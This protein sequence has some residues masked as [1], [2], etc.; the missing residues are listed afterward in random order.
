MELRQ[1]KIFSTVARERN[2]TRAAELLGYAQSNVTAQVRLL[3]DEFGTKLFERLGKRVYLSPDGEKLLQYANQI[4]KLSSEAKDALAT[5]A[6]PHGTIT[7]GVAESLCVFRLPMLFKEYCK[8][9]PQIKLILKLGASADFYRWLRDN[10]IDIAFFL[11]PEITATDLVSV[12]FLP[13][14]MVIVSNTEHRLVRKGY[15]EP[16]DLQDECLILTERGCSYRAAL[17]KILNEAGI[18]PHSTLEFGSIEAI[19]QFTAGGLGIALLPRAAVEIEL[20]HN[21]MADLH[22]VGPG[23]NM[24]TQVVYHKDKWLSPTL[25]SLLDL[26]KE[27]L[28]ATGDGPSCSTIAQL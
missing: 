21:R 14:P 11:N 5:S 2:F 19:K 3:E 17:E 8:R 16:G 1:L 7:I 28:P 12:T 20:Q 26:I 6:V 15:I 24:Y 18:Q 4:L 9:Y 22:W 27:Y 25:V 23:I 13:E 10:T